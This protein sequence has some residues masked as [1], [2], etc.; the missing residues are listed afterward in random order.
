MQGKLVAGRA[1]FHK[2]SQADK[3]AFQKRTLEAAGQQTMAPSLDMSGV[4][5]LFDTAIAN[6][7][8][9][10][11][12]RL[13][14]S[15]GQPVALSRAGKYS[16]HKG[17]IMVTDGER[18]GVNKYFGRVTETG[19]WVPSQLPQ[20]EVRVLLEKLSTNPAETAA[21]YGKLTGNCCFCL[22]PLFGEDGRST[23]VGYGPICAEKFGLPW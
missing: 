5:K 20:P 9:Y 12:I 1:D 22:R 6:G 3:D 23:A 16:K 11:K 10:P 17:Q 21:Q 8:K 14:T 13:Q 2:C 18:F 19:V 4:N 15:T 7:L